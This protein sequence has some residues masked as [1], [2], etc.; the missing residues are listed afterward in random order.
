MTF[1]DIFSAMFFYQFPQA[2]A[3]V[4]QAADESNVFPSQQAEICKHYSEKYIPYTNCPLHSLTNVN[5]FCLRSLYPFMMPA[6]IID[7]EQR[8]PPTEQYTEL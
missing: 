6:M 8:D 7:N 1:T 4:A 3:I 2:I 5:I